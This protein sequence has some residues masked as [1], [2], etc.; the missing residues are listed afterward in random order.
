MDVTVLPRERRSG[1]KPVP[2]MVIYR[3]L[4]EI[5]AQ[6]DDSC[7]LDSRTYHLSSQHKTFV[8]VFSE[9]FKI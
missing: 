9:T 6:R 2:L 4:N 8:I 7:R 3:L 5:G 1:R